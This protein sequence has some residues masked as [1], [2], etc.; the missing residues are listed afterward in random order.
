VKEIKAIIQ[1]FVAGKVLDALHQIPEMPGVTVSEVRGYGRRREAK[2][3]DRDSGVE[4]FG[5]RRVK[6]ETVVPEPLVDQVTE[7]IARAAHTGNP[8]D[9]KIFVIPVW[10]VVK[11]RTGQR[12]EGAI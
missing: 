5:D 2:P 3:G 9:G 10:D 4:V 1:P 7:A 11:I 8:G 6:L 12:G